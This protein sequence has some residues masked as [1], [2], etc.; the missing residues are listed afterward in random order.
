MKLFP[1][2]RYR[3]WLLCIV[4][5]T[6]IGWGWVYIILFKNSFGVD[7]TC[8]A[9]YYQTPELMQKCLGRA[10]TL[11]TLYR[12]FFLKSIIITSILLMLFPERAFK[13]WRW[14]AMFAVPLVLYG[15]NGPSSSGSLFSQQ[16]MSDFL[17]YIFLGISLLIAITAT[18]FDFIK[19]RRISKE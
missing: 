14:F 5:L 19:K 15:L 11:Y 13:W 7:F 9:A 6:A 2:A 12:G 1:I 18:A 8:D 4:A 16:V 10:E 3:L 17:G